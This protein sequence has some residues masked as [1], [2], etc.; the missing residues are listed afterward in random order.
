MN[1]ASESWRTLAILGPFIV[2]AA[3]ALS[4]GLI[5]LLFP[6]MKRYALARPNARSSHKE[7]TAQG[8]GFAVMAATIVVGLACLLLLP[9]LRT[10][11]ISNVIPV[12]AAAALLALLG[13][14]DDIR[15]VPVI[16]RLVLQAFAVFIVIASL[17]ENLRVISDMPPWA[18]RILLVIGGIYFVNIVNFMDGIDW[19]TAAEVVPIAAAL[20]LLSTV[21]SLPVEA[22]FVV[23]ALLGAIL[24]FVPFNR[25]VARL[26]LGDVGSLPIGLLLGWLLVLLA[27]SGHLVAALLLPLY[28]L[29]DSTITL[30][31]RISRGERIWV[32]H[33]THFYQRATDRGFRVIEIV[34]MIF[35][36]NVALATLAVLTVLMPNPATQIIG[37][38]LGIALVGIL[39]LLLAHGKARSRGKNH[40]VDGSA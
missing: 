1:D 21:G 39:L 15:D 17:P 29:A 8:G 28:Y 6:V 20:A 30:L 2:M 16:V 14:I 31:L 27:G 7:P 19:I 5:A 12:L 40:A 36:V 32:A 18:E 10:G 26:F 37:L 3:M 35:V 4:A 22:F 38:V 11:V 25:P 13:A 24:G 34:A 33:R 23:L 9:G